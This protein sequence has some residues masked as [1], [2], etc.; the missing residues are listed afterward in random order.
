MLLEFSLNFCGVRGGSFLSLI[1]R[2]L[3]RGGFFGFDVGENVTFERQ[4]G[5]ITRRFDAGEGIRGRIA[6]GFMF[7]TAFFDLNA[8]SVIC[9]YSYDLL[10]SN[11]RE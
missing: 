8:S 4:V 10:R 2:R 3:S 6:A 11:A 9:E 7:I 5:K 1:S